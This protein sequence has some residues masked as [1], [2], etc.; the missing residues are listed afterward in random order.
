MSSQLT[1]TPAS[2]R[3]STGLVRGIDFSVRHIT[4][5]N[6]TMKSSEAKP[7]QS[8][9]NCW[10]R[11][12]TLSCG[13]AVVPLYWLRLRDALAPVVPGVLELACAAA[14]LELGVVVDTAADTSLPSAAA[15]QPLKPGAE[16]DPLDK[17]GPESASGHI[18]AT[19]LKSAIVSDTTG[20][21]STSDSHRSLSRHEHHRPA[22][23]Q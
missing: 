15:R 22:D 12:V 20:L 8:L 21:Q 5:P 3:I 16:T 1:S 13:W 6:R 4:T 18:V 10:M 19:G 14:L 9:P 11:S 17:T 7:C 23:P 2:G